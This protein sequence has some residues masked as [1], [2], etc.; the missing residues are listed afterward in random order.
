[1]RVTEG[2]MAN[3]S[4][5]NLQRVRERIEQ[6]YQEVS[7]GTKVSRPGDDPLTAQQ[8]LDLNGLLEDGEQ[9]AKNIS[10]GTTYLSSMES[11]L[12]GM[13]DSL[14]RVKEL[15]LGAANGTLGAEQ[16]QS[17]KRE[18]VQL[19][20]QLITLGNSQ[21]NGRYVFSGFRNDVPPFDTNGAYSGGDGDLRVQIDRT[22]TVSVNYTGD[23]ILNGAGGGT[24]VIATLDTL[25]TSLEN[26]DTAGI[27]GT[28][29]NIDKS[30][31]QLLTAR[32]DIGA[33]MNRLERAGSFIDDTRLYLQKVI[34]SKQDVDFVK[35]VSD[36]TR[37][38][39]AFEAALAATSKISKMSLLDYM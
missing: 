33:R 7:T 18:V 27:Q 8:I 10:T 12:S 14:V 35:A 17:V 21:I 36:M 4:L 37:Q 34:S 30:V 20:E 28:L 3:K 25:I 38:Q 16:R 24:D 9:Y 5:T 26:N 23:K 39:T 15:A 11:A 13:G 29:S 2:T 6:L 1:M 22:N 19:K 31:D 32:S